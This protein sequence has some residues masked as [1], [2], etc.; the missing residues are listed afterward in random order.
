MGSESALLAAGPSAQ[1]VTAD[2]TALYSLPRWQRDTVREAMPTQVSILCR[3]R[4]LGFRPK[5]STP[6]CDAHETP[7]ADQTDVR[8]PPR[9]Q[10]H[11]G[12]PLLTGVLSSV[13]TKA[14]AGDDDQLGA[15]GVAVRPGRGQ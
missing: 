13:R 3:N 15:V 2:G 8:Y 11:F 4:F 7:K 1:H 14:A 12:G 6:G 10:H 9:S 5:R